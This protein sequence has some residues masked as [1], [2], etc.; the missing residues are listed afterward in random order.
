MLIETHY[1]VLWCH[2][3]SMQQCGVRDPRIMSLGKWAVMYHD[4]H[5]NRGAWAAHPYF[6]S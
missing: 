6:S 4:G 1:T 3:D 2:S 5:C